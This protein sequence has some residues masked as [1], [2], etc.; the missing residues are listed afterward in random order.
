MNGSTD[1]I[2]LWIAVMRALISVTV[3]PITGVVT[4]ER[5]VPATPRIRWDAV[6]RESALPV[7]SP[8]Q[9]PVPCD[10]R[11]NTLK[12]NDTR[13]FGKTRRMV[14]AGMS[15]HVNQSKCND[16]RHFGSFPD[17]EY[18]RM[19]SEGARLRQ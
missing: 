1:S 10:A 5:Q 6:T 4:L 11:T 17:Q 9:P 18:A 2:A 12:C 13:H 8:A 16:M 14:S 15:H 3:L 7:T 19:C